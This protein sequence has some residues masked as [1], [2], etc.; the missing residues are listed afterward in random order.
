[1]PGSL[2]GIFPFTGGEVG[3]RGVE[4]VLLLVVLATAVATSARRLRVPA[5]SL[6]VVAGLL[7]ALIPGVPTVRLA[8]DTVSLIVLPPLLY[9]AG[10]DLPWRELRPVWRPV[11][12]L[13]VGL[14]LAS[15]A[16]V[17]V[18]ATRIAGLPTS[19]AFVLGAV[20]ASTDPVAVTALG[21]RLPLPARLQALIQAES[22]FNDATSLVLFRVAVAAALAGG[23]VSWGTGV[24]QFVLLG[25]GGAVA[26][27]VVAYGVSLI[28]RRTED[29]VLETVI[30]LITPYAAYLGAEVAH[31]SG[32]T[33]VVVASVIL[34]GQGARLTNAR[35][36]LQVHAVYDTV[37]FLLE[38][39]VFSLIGL[40]LPSLVRDMDGQSW[41]WVGQAAA[42]AGT[43]LAVRALWVFPLS[44]L[45][46]GRRGWRVP[47]VVSWAGARGVLPL[48]AALSI[49]LVADDGTPLAGRD[50][51]LLLTT[52]V[53]VA[54]LVV[55]GFTL[56]PLVRRSGI[57]VP[58]DLARDEEAVA[59]QAMSR[60]ALAHLDEVAGLD[61]A[62]PAALARLREAVRAR[63]DHAGAEEP[64]AT[65][66]V[67]RRL[68][69]D[70]IAVEAAEL[71]R[72]YE[73]GTIG[74]ATRRR[75]QRRLD[76]EETSLDGT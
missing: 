15:A 33:A 76:L 35:I 71:T 37:V 17:G 12:V 20:L 11:T 48:A 8:P 43:L 51:V 34:A 52:A 26:G 7:V 60:A 5:P 23:A 74:A 19:M 16:A 58:P 2:V 42:I 29:P 73:D 4:I 47:V 1:M 9:A 25:G 28:R 22:L 3:V 65:G 66:P 50:H 27:A 64:D 55:Q 30:A 68:R 39:V 6:L 24:A 72:L 56:G 41:A 10:Q 38:S 32:V 46:P 62:P 14:V 67:L 70:L 61:A 13:A 53:I 54:T 21:R 18:V 75:L 40:E 36:R 49:P 45:A 44:L 63:L 31:V 57:A 69:R 59:R